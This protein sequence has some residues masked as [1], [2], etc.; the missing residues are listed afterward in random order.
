MSEALFTTGRI[1]TLDHAAPLVEALAVRGGRIVA[2][3]R[4]EELRD[5]FSALRRIDLGGRTVVPG[6]VDSHI[7]LPSYGI[8]LRRVD[9]RPTRTLR[10]AVVLVVAAVKRERSGSWVQGR[11]WDKNVWP[12]ARFPA[13]E[14]LDPV[15]PDH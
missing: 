10:E 7:H 3:G 13:K 8:S 11:G 9:L 12:E 4:T 2:A 6:F 1:Y 5:A 15:S 14:D